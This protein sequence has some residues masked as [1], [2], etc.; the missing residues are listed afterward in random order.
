M[1]V[2]LAVREGRG[3]VGSGTPLGKKD[4]AEEIVQGGMRQRIRDVLGGAWRAGG[5]VKRV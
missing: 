3:C 1:R 4:E 5:L 2:L